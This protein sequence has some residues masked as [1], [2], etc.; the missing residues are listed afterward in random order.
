MR[1]APILFACLFAS[2]AAFL[3]LSPVL[4]EMARDLDLPLATVGQ[5]GTAAG[6]AGAVAAVGITVAGSRLGVRSLLLAGLALLALGSAGTAVAPAFGW[7]LAAQLALGAGVS[8]VLAG[9]I[10]AVPAWAP[11]ARR[12]TVLAWALVGQPAAWVLGMPVIGL[13]AHHE[14]RLAW[15]AVPCTAAIVALVLVV[16]GA[17][18]GARAPEQRR[19]GAPA[20]RRPAVRAWAAGEVLGFLAWNG[21]LLY[22]G[23]LLQTSYGLAPVAIGLVLGGCAAAYLPGVWLARPHVGEHA[24]AMLTTACL[25]AAVLSATLG[26]QRSSLP[27]TAALVVALMLLNGVRG[28]S[29]S[30]LGLAIAPDRSVELTGLRATAVQTGGLLGAALG[31]IAL[32]VGG[33]GAM[34][35]VFAVAFVLAAVPHVH[36]LRSS[37]CARLDP[38][39]TAGRARR[40]AARDRRRQAAGA[41]GPARHR[42]RAPRVAR[43]AGRRRVGRR[44]AA[45]RAARAPVARLA[46]AQGARGRGAHRPGGGRLPAGADARLRRRAAVRAARARGRGRASRG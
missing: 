39:P 15:L 35:T 4:P 2:Q 13:V 16:A 14:W 34:T 1:P 40:S 32:D 45:R 37:R 31:G 33:M 25:A 46:P 21:T 26:L 41:P 42:R 22:V 12:P 38:G 28:L 3:T 10:A 44:P 6:L 9:G 7:L 17:G 20:W 5:L 19:A 36:A 30:A 18:S 11:P 43:S 29:G 8:A 27:I 23:A 24:R